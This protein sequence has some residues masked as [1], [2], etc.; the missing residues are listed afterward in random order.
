ML[1]NE[2]KL[3]ARE[4]SIPVTTHPVLA[5]PVEAITR[6]AADVYAD[7][8]VLGSKV[9]HGARHLSYVPNAVMDTATCAVLIV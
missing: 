1:L 9:S 8:I 2:L 5:D 4:A 6:V 3:K 7:L